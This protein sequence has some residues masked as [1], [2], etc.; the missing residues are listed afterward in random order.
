M[1]K[2]VLVIGRFRGIRLEVH[3]SWLIIFALLLTTMS[4]GFR[5]QYPDWTT[6]T[7]VLTA[8]VTALS[9]GTASA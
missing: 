9:F 4:A 6:A 2:S 8:L 5:H 3:V 7:A 1:F